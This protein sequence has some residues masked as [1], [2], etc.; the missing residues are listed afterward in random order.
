ME[1][2]HFY[3]T[4]SIGKKWTIEYHLHEYLNLM[5]LIFDGGY[6]DWGDS[7]GRAWC[8][9]CHIFLDELS[10]EQMDA[11]EKHTLGHLPNKTVNSRLACQIPLNK[12]LHQKHLSFLGDFEHLSS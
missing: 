10:E 1:K 2:Y 4:D 3:Y 12:A 11:D 8:G 7:R 6:E 9:T 5:V